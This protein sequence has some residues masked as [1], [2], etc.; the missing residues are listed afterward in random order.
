ML[1]HQRL[2]SAIDLLAQR[3]GLSASGLARKAGLDPTTFNRSKRQALDGRQRWPSTESISKV[4][5]A[6]ETSIEE[7]FD[8]AAPPQDRVALS[9][10]RL[11]LL[12]SREARDPRHF[13]AAGQPAGNGWDEVPF[14][15][16]D[17]TVRD[18]GAFA[19][20]VDGQ[21]MQPLYNDGDVV[22]VAPGAQI[23]RGDRVLLRTRKGELLARV[24]I[25]HTARLIELHGGNPEAP[26]EPIDAGEVEWLARIVW[27]SQ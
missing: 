10:C 19:L 26:D 13:T 25:R 7:F 23:R 21:S 4:L 22:V 1:S 20:A 2:W 5:T 9:R 12:G 14:I 8:I 16:P 3:R 17:P 24:L 18:E 15:A 27:V 11:P 6:T